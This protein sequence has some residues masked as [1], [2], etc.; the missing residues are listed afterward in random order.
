[1]HRMTKGGANTSQ[2]ARIHLLVRKVYVPH[3]TSQLYI[4]LYIP[5]CNLR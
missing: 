2:T 4:C 1:M 5:V 3:D